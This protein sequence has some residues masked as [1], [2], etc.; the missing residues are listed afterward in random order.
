[1]SKKNK[2]PTYNLSLKQIEGIEKKATDEAVDKAFILMLGLPIMA[3]HDYYPKIMK[4]QGREETFMNLV[5]DQYNAFR[6]G[7]IT[8]EDVANCLK[9]ECGLKI[10]LKR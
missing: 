10:E 3:I 7:Y 8:L 9:E 2:N 4:K 5:I 1:M 6:E